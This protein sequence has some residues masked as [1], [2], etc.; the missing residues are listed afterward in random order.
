LNSPA[1]RKLFSKMRMMI[2]VGGVLR[3]AAGHIRAIKAL[4]GRRENAVLTVTTG[5]FLFALRYS[6]EE[7]LRRF[8]CWSRGS[9]LN[10]IK[11]RGTGSA[12]T[13]LY[14]HIP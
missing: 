12:G 14:H 5:A 9:K 13:P 2:L 6:A 8:S 7:T 4:G 11:S 3:M 10:T 1:W